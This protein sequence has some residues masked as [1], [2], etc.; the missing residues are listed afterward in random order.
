MLPNSGDLIDLY[1]DALWAEKGLAQQTLNAYRSDLTIYQKWLASRGLD[2]IEVSEELVQAYFQER[3][4]QGIAASTS[5]RI[6]SSLDSF[7]Q[8]TLA[9]NLIDVDPTRRLERPKLNRTLPH[10]MSESRIDALLAAP[11]CATALGMRDK[12]M[13]E[14]MYATGLRVSELVALKNTQINYRM[15]VV[16]LIGKGNKE[17]LVPFNDAAHQYLL[18]YLDKARP[19]LSRGIISTDVFISSRGKGLTR[20][21]FWH[22][23]K[24]YAKAIGMSDSPSPHTLRHCFA[25]HLLN[26]GADLRVVQLL[27][28]HTDL[29]T[30]QIYTH[31]AKEGLKKIHAR[32]HPRA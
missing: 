21:A 22:R 29:S 3:I 5:S 4:Q 19:Q 30:T 20:Q 28:G 12:A 14:F 25:T 2:L 11:D 8:W 6:L 9:K 32:H 10:S 26:H 1:I 24:Y 7:Y 23:I 27:L 18:N 16:R 31:V 15:G 13:L 17:R